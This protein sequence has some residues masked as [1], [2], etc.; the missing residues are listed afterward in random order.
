MRKLLSLM[1]ILL[2][3]STSFS[4]AKIKEISA[5][6]Q[7]KFKEA[8]KKVYISDFRV[9]YQVLFSQTE[10]AEGGRE[11]GGGQRGDAVA[12]LTMGIKGLSQEDL[13][14]ITDA[15]YTYY[16]Q[17]FE[18]MGYSFVSAEEASKIEEFA[19][20]EM[21]S[22]GTFNEA[23]MP[24]L[25][26]TVP[27]NHQYLIKSTTG[28][29]KEKGGFNGY[30][31]SA[32][33]GGII[34]ASFNTDVLFVEDAESFA[35]KS[36]GDAVGGVAKI[37]VRPNLRLA[38]ASTNNQFFFA[39]K[40]VKP[41]S[42]T[43]MELKEPVLIPGV[44]EDKKYKAAESSQSDMWGSDLGAMKVFHVSDSYL[45]KTIPLECESAKYTG[46]VHDAIKAYIDSIFEMYAAY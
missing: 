28:K 20:Y 40:E 45:S 10:V 29:G 6:G 11:I 46:G 24:G 43:K 17:Q 31:A 5:I 27:T 38:Q 36:L 22:G 21:K 15:V 7:K 19:G 1:L 2:I 35:S 33:L 9:N 25:I 41:L 44:F 34:I 4:Q 26:S 14:G 13:M 8:Q 18:K 42:F 3:T 12:G 37:V 32:Q 23:Q 39:E 30:R 16:K